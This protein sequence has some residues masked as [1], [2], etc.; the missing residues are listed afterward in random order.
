MFVKLAQSTAIDL[1][2]LLPAL[3]INLWLL[4]VYD[5]IYLF[6]SGTPILLLY[7]SGLVKSLNSNSS[8]IFLAQGHCLF[9]LAHDLLDQ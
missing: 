4:L 3:F 9:T 5:F 7:T 6:L 1:Q 2:S 8:H